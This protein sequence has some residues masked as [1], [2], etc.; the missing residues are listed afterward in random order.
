[1]VYVTALASTEVKPGQ[2]KCSAFSTHVETVS[3]GGGIIADSFV[4]LINV[5]P[6]IGKKSGLL[7]EEILVPIKNLEIQ[8]VRSICPEGR[9]CD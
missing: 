5:K 6:E 3:L 7:N 8:S 9:R 4:E 1:M 2:A